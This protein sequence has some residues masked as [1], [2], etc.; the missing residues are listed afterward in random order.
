MY[1]HFSEGLE[2]TVQLFCQVYQN[3]FIYNVYHRC[4]CFI[5]NQ[6]TMAYEQKLIDDT[7]FW[8]LLPLFQR[9]DDIRTGTFSSPSVTKVRDRLKYV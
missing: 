4:L 2:I 3:A 7:C 5:L 8:F 1:G 9:L 6:A